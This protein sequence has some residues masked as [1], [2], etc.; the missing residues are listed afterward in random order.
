MGMDAALKAAEV[1]V[2][3]Y[4]PPPSETNYMGVILTG[5]QSACQAA[6]I[7][8]QDMIL[9]VATRPLLY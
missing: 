1:N 2:V 9:E 6:A 4:T 3:S 7:A 5:E 8:F